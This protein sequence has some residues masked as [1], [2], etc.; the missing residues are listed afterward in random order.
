MARKT[1]KD[2]RFC[3]ICERVQ[4]HHSQPSD[5]N[6]RSVHELEGHEAGWLTSQRYFR[7]KRTVHCRGCENRLELVEMPYE[8]LVSLEKEVK[9][10]RAMRD[11]IRR[12]CDS[13]S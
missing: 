7:W 2:D 3:D 4:E 9:G 12:L 6:L 13:T 8:H 11:E 5:P 10:L 1:Y